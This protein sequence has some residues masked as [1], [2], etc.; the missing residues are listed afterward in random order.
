[1]LGRS[2]DLQPVLLGSGTPK[3]SCEDCGQWLECGLL[4][5]WVAEGQALDEVSVSELH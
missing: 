5:P 3:E 2:R 1:M 4:F